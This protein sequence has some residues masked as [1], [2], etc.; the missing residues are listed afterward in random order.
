MFEEPVDESVAI[1]VSTPTESRARADSADERITSTESRARSRSKEREEAR[2]DDAERRDLGVVARESDVTE[3]LLC[4]L[5][6]DRLK[7]P[8]A[9]KYETLNDKK[10]KRGK[11][12]VLSTRRNRR[13][14]EK[15]SP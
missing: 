6:D 10:E 4:F 14:F 1:D 13:R 12:L 8:M 15:A 11:T 5:A 2:W 7:I 3:S 9:E